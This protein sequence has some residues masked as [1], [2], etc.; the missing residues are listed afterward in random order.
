VTATTASIIESDFGLTGNGEN[1]SLFELTNSNGMTAVI[2]NYGGALVSLTAASRDGTLEN[3]VLGYETLAEYETGTSYIGA[4][5]GR[6]GNRIAYAKFSLDGEVYTLARNNGSN[7]LHGGER[8]FDKVVW[9]A[10]PQM[11]DQG[12]SLLLKYT[13][14][15]GEQGYPGTLAV[16]VCCTLTD[17]N[18]LTID[19]R[20]ITDKA[21][22][23]NLTS[24]SYFNLSGD[25]KR[26]ILGHQLEMPARHFTPV[27][28][29]LI[30]TGEVCRV[31]DSPFDFRV[32]KAVGDDIDADSQ[33]IV[34]GG[35]YDHNWIVDQRAD[36]KMRHMATLSDPESGRVLKVHSTEPG[37]QFYSGNF[38][39]EWS[40]SDAVVFKTR[41]GLCLET[42]HFPDSPNR[43]KFPSTILQP[44]ELYSTRTVFSF[45]TA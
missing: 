41:Y 29:V 10:E 45:S 21:T 22:P 4:L 16:E 3:I 30:P 1:V 43:S 19:Y 7:H 2:T 8:G 28:S 25:T 27:D 5:I 23:V 26:D 33:Q 38:L 13:S 15:D 14:V 32:A 24:H 36:G 40:N 35:G 34:Y 11:L 12:P 31:D 42:Q 9:Q 6:Y 37:L 20:A 39:D 44:G 17:N 18:Q